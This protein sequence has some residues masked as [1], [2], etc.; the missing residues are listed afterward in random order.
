MPRASEAAFQR[1]RESQKKRNLPQNRRSRVLQTR[2]T[3]Q[4]YRVIEAMAVRGGMNVSEWLREAAREKLEKEFEG[5]GVE[6][7][8]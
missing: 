5:Y 2:V 6:V 1:Q 7:R 8:S 4:A 3:D